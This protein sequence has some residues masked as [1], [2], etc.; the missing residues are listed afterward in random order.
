MK[1]QMIG[2]VV[3]DE[4]VNGFDDVHGLVVVCGTS[5]VGVGSGPAKTIRNAIVFCRST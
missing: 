1:L 4:F 3:V 5:E 2:D